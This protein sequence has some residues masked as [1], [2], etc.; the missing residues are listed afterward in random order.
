M[1]GKPGRFDGIAE[2]VIAGR[3]GAHRVGDS[4]ECAVVM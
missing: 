4:S 3:D 2:F 1:A